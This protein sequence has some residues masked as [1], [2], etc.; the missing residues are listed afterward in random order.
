MKTWVL[1]ANAGVAF[2][3]ESENLRTK[4]L[5]LIKKLQH[6]ASREK[7]NELVSDRPGDYHAEHGARSGYEKPN[8]KEI[9]AEN[10]ARE[11]AVMIVHSHNIHN[12]EQLI[13]LS[14]PHFYGLINKHLTLKNGKV[15]HIPKDYTKFSKNDLL[16]HVR[17]HLYG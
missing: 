9:E 3:Y 6:P 4:T 1:V 2:V 15:I 10:F 13:L 11:L 8:P 14:S 7:E 5:T 16:D 17:K 12:F